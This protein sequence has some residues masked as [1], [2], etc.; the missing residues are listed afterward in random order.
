MATTIS[1][2]QAGS[3]SIKCIALIEGCPHVLSDAPT[4]AVQAALAGTDWASASVMPL[5][6]TLQNQ[7]K[8]EPWEPFATGGKCLLHV[9]N[10]GLDT[11]G[12]LVSKRGGG[13]LT[14]LTTAVDRND[15]T[16]TVKS[17]TAFTSS[18][19]LYIGTEAIEYTG[20]TSTTFT[21]CTRG[22]FSPF[23]GEASG[24]AGSRFGNHH[25]IG[26]DTNHVVTKP[27]V[28]Q[29]PRVWLGKLV[30]VWLYTWNGTSL[31][32]K[33]DAQLVFA[34]RIVGISDNHNT[35]NI[36]IELEHVLDGIPSTVLGKDMH[37]ADVQDG[38]YLA[39]GRRFN[40]IDWKD[41]SAQKDAN[42]LDVVASGATGTN[43]INA[44]YYTVDEICAVLSKWLAA[45]QYAGRLYGYYSWSSPVSSN[46][47]LRTKVHWKI[48]H[49][50]PGGVFTDNLACDWSIGMPP[51]VDC[52]LGIKNEQPDSR[53]MAGGVARVPGKTNEDNTFVGEFCPMRNLVFKPFGPGRIG[54]EFATEG[55]RYELE[56]EI[57]AFT[58]QRSL[59][60]AALKEAT[61]SGSNWG[62]YLLDD[63]IL[64]VASYASGVLTNAWLAP[65]QITSDDDRDA[66][67]YIG[68]RMDADG[69]LTVRQV[70]VFESSLSTLLLALSYS[71]GTSGYNSSTYDTLAYGFGLGIPGELLGPV[72]DRSVTNLP[73]ADAQ[74]VVVIDEPTKFEDLIG[75]DALIRRAFLRWKD[76]RLC[77]GMWQ[78]PTLGGSVLTLEEQNKAGPAG[79]VV[80]HRMP[81]LETNQYQRPIVKID[82]SRDYA[83]GRGESYLRS[84]SFEDQTAV[85]DMGGGAKTYTIKLR[86]T[87]SQFTNTGQAVEA[88]LPGFLAFM[89]LFS[90]AV[91][92]ITRSISLKQYEGYSVGDVVTVNDDFARDPL[93]GTRGISNRPAFITRIAYDIGGPNPESP[94]SPRMMD[95][96]VDL[97]FLDLHR[98]SEYAP[99]ADVDD[100]ANAGGFSAGYNSGTNTLR[101]KARSYSHQITITNGRGVA[102]LIDEAHDAENID[103][104]DKILIVERDPQNTASPISWEREVLSQSSDDITLTTGLSSP[105]WDNT[106]KYRIV[107]QKYSQVT[108]TQKEESVYQADD[109]DGMIEDTEVPSHFSATEE[110]YDYTA[111]AGTEDAEL[112]PDMSYGDGRPWDVGHDRAL[113]NTVNKL[114]DYKTAHQGPQLWNTFHNVNA[115]NAYSPVFFGPCFFGI[116]IITTSVTRTLSVAPFFRS[117]SGG[118]ASIR[119]TIMDTPPVSYPGSDPEFYVGRFTGKYASATWSTTSTTWQ[120]GIAANLSLGVKDYNNGCLWLLIEKSGQGECRGLAKYIES[121]RVVL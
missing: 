8:I 83:V 14:E 76:Q 17:T 91:R 68:R 4:A 69:P 24:S 40:F 101:C 22:K 61:A 86:H 100:T 25:R 49:E 43:Q 99:A 50:N 29:E 74:L 16:L 11:F 77:W 108:A 27:V 59:L 64:M 103:V 71:S 13:A 96:D 41:G 36:D 114:L 2:L 53:G 80:S 7:V 95:G 67:P 63:R 38:L 31:N 42:A 65:F 97:M 19:T 66:L 52:L 110:P 54:Q 87:S 94:G 30:G 102:V 15:T 106:K 12:K 55:L 6:I 81:T 120:T 104:G 45:E 118:S 116:E 35:F 93:T 98:P 18:G 44:G 34:G 117:K 79:S 84:A 70:Y 92:M 56:N 105:A 78:T 37:R 39:T 23:G 111:N 58:D 113:I 1:A 75:G 51:E 3:A 109:A 9:G 20:K 90:R 33:A 119:V 88:L 85:D 112:V 28:S 115:G 57:G 26:S 107:P 10:D 5:F 73:G 46:T 89:P 21:G 32:T 82:Y 47:G 121:A 48:P 72:Y 60:P 62:L